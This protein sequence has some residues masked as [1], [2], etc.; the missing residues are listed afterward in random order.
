MLNI[1]FCDKDKD[2]LLKI[3]PLTKKIFKS[4]KIDTNIFIFTDENNLIASFKT[5][6]SYYDI[7]FL[8]ID[9]INGKKIV[10]EL[11][12]L[13][14]NFKLILLTSS[15][16]VTLNIFQYDVIEFLPKK[17]IFQSLFENINRI[18]TDIKEHDPQIQLFKVTN[19]DRTMIIRIPLFEMM[20]FES[21]NRKVHLYTKRETYILHRYHFSEIVQK[22][23]P[24]GFID[25]YRT[26]IVN[27]IY[28]FSVSDFEIHLYNGICLPISR[29]KK[30]QIITEIC[31]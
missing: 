20:Y 3:A 16:Y 7:V 13:N 23:I 19:H 4:F 17:F 24:L 12:I 21:I 1:A 31:R 26:C 2:F 18:V 14:K 28:I 10:Q 29:R 25:I 15:E 5:Y 22:Y 27:T 8:D 6:Q 11:R 9:F 30:Q